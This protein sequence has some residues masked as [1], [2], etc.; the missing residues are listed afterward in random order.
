M[1]SD[2][3]DGL[4][5]NS[6]EQYQFF[7]HSSS[8]SYT[9]YL[10]DVA[11]YAF[12]F[13]PTG[14]HACDGSLLSIAENS[15]LFALIGTTYGGDG[16]TTFAV[17]DLRGRTPLGVGSS[18]TGGGTILL[19]ERSG[20]EQVTLTQNNLPIHTHLLK[21]KAAVGSTANPA[22][23]VFATTS[24]EANQPLQYGTAG[25]AP[26]VV[27]KPNTLIPTGGSTPVSLREPFLGMRWCIALEGIFPSQP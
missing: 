14:W 11:L 22:N 16:Q 8:M 21:A 17:P 26:A 20:S 5:L 12:N 1:A 3:H 4:H 15:A 25:T 13:V 24:T 10:G 9:P 6:I 19:G 23:E 27:S 18:T 2:R 7:L